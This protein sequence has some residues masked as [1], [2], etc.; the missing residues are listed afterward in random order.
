MIIHRPYN[1]KIVHEVCDCKHL[2]PLTWK[3]LPMYESLEPQ[4]NLS[5]TSLES[6]IERAEASKKITFG[7]QS[8]NQFKFL[9]FFI[10]YFTS[11]CG[12]GGLNIH[13]FIWGIFLLRG[14]TIV[15]FCVI[16]RWFHVLTLSPASFWGPLICSYCST[17]RTRV[18]ARP[19]SST[20]FMSSWPLNV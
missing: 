2:L 1:I 20:Y 14:I 7:W 13:Q 16:L 18:R 12:S 10:K 17:L 5:L 11:F 3:L 8:S 19:V 9:Y 6:H 4:Q 15:K